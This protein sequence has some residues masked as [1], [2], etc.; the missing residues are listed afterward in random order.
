MEKSLPIY[1]LFVKDP[2]FSVWM[3][4]GVNDED[5]ET[6]FGEK[7]PVY[8]IVTVEGKPYSFLGKPPCA[9]PL[10]I[11]GVEIT[12]FSTI[13]HCSC[14][15]FSLKAEYISPLD[16]TDVTLT[17]CPVCMFR[18]ELAPRRPLAGCQVA[19]AVSE[20]ICYNKRKAILGDV[21]G[22]ETHQTAY[23]GRCEQALLSHAADVCSAD[24]GYYY[25]RA[26]DAY[27]LGED[28]F[29]AYL[30]TG[31][32]DGSLKGCARYLL[33]IDRHAGEC[34]AGGMM[35]LAF[36][37]VCSVYY[38]GELLRG[39]Y[40]RNG[41]NI[42][43]ALDEMQTRAPQI[44]A[45]LASFDVRL[46]E[47][48]EPFG[49]EYLHILYASLRQAMGAHK[50]VADGKG[51][52]LFLS[53]ECGSDGC[54]ATV[55]ISYP[56]MPLFLLCAPQ[57]LKGML[58]P[59]FDFAERKVWRYAFAPHDAGIYPYCVG[60]FY[61]ATVMKEGKCGREDCYFGKTDVT[62]PPYYLYPADNVLYD[63]SKQM[64]VEE[65]SNML[66]L[67]ALLLQQGDTELADRYPALLEKWA[68]Y[69]YRCPTFPDSQLCTDDFAGHLDK[70]VNLAIK[71]AV[72]LYAY[73]VIAA[74]AADGNAAKR[75]EAAAKHRARE[76]A[77]L[78]KENG[79]MLP[80]TSE[81]GKGTFSI[82]YNLLA[83]RLL[84]GG[85]FDDRLIEEEVDGYLERMLPYGTPLDVRAEYTK[86][87]WLLWAAALTRSPEK[88][89]KFFGAVSAYLSDSKENIPFSD[90]YDSRSGEV[91]KYAEG[92]SFRNRTVQAACFAPLLLNEMGL[93][94]H[95]E[96]NK[97]ER[98]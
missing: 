28:A 3:P 67:T 91:W 9:E 12:A 62:L 29:L 71:A 92:R 53:K 24:W 23:F 87:D 13:V 50:L 95:P 46:C 38:Y 93:G 40:F 18:Y 88:Q 45:Q 14:E 96:R 65:S 35:F 98:K 39:Y 30:K 57:L 5:T 84:G 33:G 19:L 75:F 34:A 61:A 26:Q 7:I 76:I 37:D 32:A 55:D 63:M 73:S 31:Q 15:L 78:R 1:P 89:K 6:W 81:G 22:G 47:R 83:D 77:D 72:G 42:L 4:R 56:S 2:F 86:S 43:D 58:Y 97:E 82:K 44:L 80:L 90:W 79:G 41:K 70:N 25:L 59:I 54:I 85:L 69:L 74:Y 64:P 16:P 49:E 66:I 48:A 52:L 68:E 20:K 8:G 17:A 51:N 10:R 21:I 27:Y 36:D 11:D 60:Q 94:A